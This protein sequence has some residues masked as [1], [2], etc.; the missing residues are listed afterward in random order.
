MRRFGLPWG[1]RGRAIRRR[2]RGLNSSSSVEE[3]VEALGDPLTE[4]RL[5]AVNALGR[6]GGERSLGPLMGALR[7]DTSSRVREAAAL[8]LAERADARAVEALIERVEDPGEW[9]GV[10]LIAMRALRRTHGSRAV[11]ALMGRLQAGSV[12][13]RRAAAVSL[14]E[15]GEERAVPGLRARL[16]DPAEGIPVRVAAARALADVGGPEAQAAL[17]SAMADRSWVVQA[18]AARSLGRIGDAQAIGPLVAAL[19]H[20]RSAVRREV[21]QALGCIAAAEA[22]QPLVDALGDREGEVREAVAAAL[23]RTG[24]TSIGPLAGALTEALQDRSAVTGWGVRGC[25]RWAD[26]CRLAAE[27]LRAACMRLPS[28]PGHDRVQAIRALAASLPAWRQA[29]R[30]LSGPPLHLRL[31]LLRLVRDVDP[32]VSEAAARDGHLLVPAAD[33]DSEQPPEEPM[34]LRPA[35]ED[36]ADGGEDTQR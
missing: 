17:V 18:E 34:D 12:V 15:I 28:A 3:L 4:V 6:L 27:V 36:R 30:S 29:A 35:S 19:A 26:A 32:V 33:P 2:V 24:V 22:I 1:L 23:L 21:A 11:A 31:E 8:A 10:C 20:E 16:E 5:A 14:G 13:L 25:H 7:R 9:S